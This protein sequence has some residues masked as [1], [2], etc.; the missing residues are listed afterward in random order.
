MMEVGDASLRIGAA[1]SASGPSVARARDAYLIALFRA[2]HAG[3]VDGV[4][5]TAEAFGRL[6]D[7]AVAD[8]CLRIARAVA[9]RTSDPTAVARVD[10][11]VQRPARPAGDLAA[12]QPF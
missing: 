6:G 9:E 8:Q 10:A 4:L 11:F 5:R 1:S 2:R 12:V 3:S 7:R